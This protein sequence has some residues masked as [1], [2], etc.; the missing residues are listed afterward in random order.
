MSHPSRDEAVAEVSTRRPSGVCS[1]GRQGDLQDSE[2]GK[3]QVR[4]LA[5]QRIPRHEIAP[6]FGTIGW[7]AAWRAANPSGY[8]W[9]PLVVEDYRWRVFRDESEAS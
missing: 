5:E 6:A 3:M 4:Q 1:P 8:Y 9:P 2:S 7:A